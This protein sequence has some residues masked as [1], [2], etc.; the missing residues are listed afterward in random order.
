MNTPFCFCTTSSYFTF[1]I[2]KIKYPMSKPSSSNAITDLMTLL[3]FGVCL[4]P[5]WSFP[6]SQQSCKNLVVLGRVVIVLPHAAPTCAQ[7]IRWIMSGSLHRR[8]WP[9][10]RLLTQRSD[11]LLYRT[12][13][14]SG[15]AVG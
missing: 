1:N 3:I 10:P 13:A 12:V 7:Q 6:D 2:Q 15:H 8:V 14:D 5:D 4:C 11:H 9:G